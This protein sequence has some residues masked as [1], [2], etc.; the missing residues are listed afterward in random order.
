LLLFLLGATGHA[1]VKTWDG[2]GANSNWSTA[3]NW[4][5]DSVPA[6]N[7]S[8]VFAGSAGTVNSNDFAAG[9]VFSGLIFSA[10]AG[11]F[12]LNGNGLALSGNVSDA[13]GVKQ[14]VNLPLGLGSA[15]RSFT[16]GAGGQLEIGQ[17]LTGSAGL[18]KDGPGELTLTA[19]NTYGG[20]TVISNGTVRLVPSAAPVAGMIYWLDAADLSTVTKGSDNK[21]SQW[22]DRSGNGRNFTQGN[23][24]LQ[25]S[26]VSDALGGKPGLRFDG[27]REFG[28]TPPRRGERTPTATTLPTRLGAACM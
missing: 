18:L 5:L 9:T 16:V 12:V 10:G 2:G 23:I 6:A 15:D 28:W 20:A 8:L 21:V 1:A 14:K 11:A 13:A 24:N 22:T 25:P 27:T 17:P 26:Y 19:R 7:D 4:D 3:G